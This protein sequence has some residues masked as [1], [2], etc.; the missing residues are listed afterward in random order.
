MNNLWLKIKVTFKI[1][2]ASAVGL[3]VLIFVINNGGRTAKFWFW[4]GRDYDYSLLFLV[5]L[6]FFI[7]VIVTILAATTFRTIR[8]IRELRARG[9]TQKL[10]REIADMKSKASMLQIRPAN[11][12]VPMANIAPPVTTDETTPT[13]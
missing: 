11:G 7:G 10:E 9:R 8:Q 2:V 1:L 12:S 13:A 5:T 4:F 6:A 3:Y